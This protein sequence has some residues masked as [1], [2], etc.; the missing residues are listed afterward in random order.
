MIKDVGQGCTEKIARI[1]ANVGTTPCVI[2]KV[3][4]VDVPQ[5]G[6]ENCTEERFDMFSWFF[7]FKFHFINF[8]CENPCP[9]GQYGMMCHKKCQCNNSKC[10]P[11]SG[12][13]LAENVKIVF[14]VAHNRSSGTMKLSSD[15]IQAKHWIPVSGNGKINIRNCSDRCEINNDDGKALN[16]SVDKNDFTK[17]A[18]IEELNANLSNLTKELKTASNKSVV[19]V[20]SSISIHHIHKGVIDAAEERHKL[21]DPLTPSTET[22]FVETENLDIIY[23]QHG[24]FEGMDEQIDHNGDSDDEIDSIGGYNDIVH[25]FAMTSINTTKS[26]SQ[27]SIFLSVK[28]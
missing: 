6:S 11:Q 14:D 28:C 4:F 10:D 19:I 5:G 27:K 7:L 1:V 3:D 17:T 25:V 23:D 12:E 24:E 21:I 18:L 22:N 20:N 16:Q 26:V 13:C 8:S 15:R 2:I 9:K